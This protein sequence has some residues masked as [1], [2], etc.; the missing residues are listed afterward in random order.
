[1]IGEFNMNLALVEDGQAFVFRQYLRERTHNGCVSQ[2]NTMKR[3]DS[4]PSPGKALIVLIQSIGIML[5]VIAA[6]TLIY[7]QIGSFV[8]KH[9]VNTADLV[10]VLILAVTISLYGMFCKS[11]GRLSE[12]NSRSDSQYNKIIVGA[13]FILASLIGMIHAFQECMPEAS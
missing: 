12:A 13:A 2:D 7:S 4:E 5:L 10:R 11:A 3:P 6:A 9:I 1:M 8:F